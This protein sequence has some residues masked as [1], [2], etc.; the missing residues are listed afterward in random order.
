MLAGKYINGYHVGNSSQ[1]GY[2]TYVPPGWGDWYGLQS[3]EFFGSR[4]NV[5]GR[6]VVYPADAYQTDIIANLSLSWLRTTW[7]KEKPFFMWVTPHAPHAPYTPAPRHKGTLSGLRQP[8]DP[9]F[10][11]PDALQAKLPG[12]MANLS[13]VNVTAMDVIYQSRAEAL[14]AVDEMI[15]DLIDEIDAQGVLDRTWIFFSCDNGYHLG[16]HRLSPGKREF[17]EHDINVPFVVRGPGLAAG[18][19]FDN[20]VIGNYDLAA[21]FAAIAGAVPTPAAPEMDGVSLLPLLTGNDSYP[22]W[23]RDWSLQEG[24]YVYLFVARALSLFVALFVALSVLSLYSLFTLFLSLRYPF[25]S[26]V[27]HR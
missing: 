18:R 17:F 21:T 19:V 26:Q 5:N 9:A 1:P 27:H 13:L 4:V 15:G 6:S 20:Q 3:I 11:L 7:Q 2:L 10:N 23:S 22:V 12:H 14:L 8:A 25:T 24:W 16:Q